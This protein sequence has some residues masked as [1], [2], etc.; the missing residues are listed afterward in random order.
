MDIIKLSLEGQSSA[1][2]A[3]GSYFFGTRRK[4]GFVLILTSEKWIHL[5]IPAGFLACVQSIYPPLLLFPRG[6]TFFFPQCPQCPPRHP[7]SPMPLSPPIAWPK[8]LQLP[9]SQ[10]TSHRFKSN[11]SARRTHTIVFI[12]LVQSLSIS[13]DSIPRILINRHLIYL[14]VVALTRWFGTTIVTLL[15]ADLLALWIECS[16]STKRVSIICHEVL[17][18][19]ITEY[20]LSVKKPL[21][22]QWIRSCKTDENKSSLRS[23][24]QTSW[25]QLSPIK[26]TSIS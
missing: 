7:M 1:I 22:F 11:S 14:S 18:K 3:N 13:K 2:W 12:L 6:L 15:S 5:Q 23:R 24:G 19:W 26:I 9:V 8:L 4:S 17:T 20:F 16:L 21:L 10:M 25:R